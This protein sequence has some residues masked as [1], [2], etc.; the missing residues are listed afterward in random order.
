MQH[1]RNA[2]SSFW[3]DQTTNGWKAFMTATDASWT[4][5]AGIRVLVRG[6]RTQPENLT[7]SPSAPN[8]VTLDMTGAVNTGNQNIALS[9]AGNYHL[10][11]NP[12][13][14]PTDIGTVVDATTNI[15]TMYWVWDAN[16]VS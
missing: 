4:Q 15:G 14:S 5:Y 8:A 1:Q 6:D 13:P 3:F 7:A 16:A 12:Y 10:V 9:T 2:A 11:S